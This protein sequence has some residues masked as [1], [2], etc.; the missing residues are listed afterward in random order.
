MSLPVF[1]IFFLLICLFNVISIL[2]LNSDINDKLKILKDWH[3]SGKHG[4]QKAGCLL[5]GYEAFRTL[6]FYHLQKKRIMQVPQTR[7]DSIKKR[8]EET[9]LKPGES[10]FMKHK[11][12]LSLRL[13]KVY[14]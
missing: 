14:L 4:Y 9:L 3:N 6:V 1:L 7:L 13:G 12:G 10:K 11:I 2:L 8:I 5:I